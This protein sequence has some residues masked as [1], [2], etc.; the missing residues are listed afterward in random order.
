MLED[1]GG[2]IVEITIFGWTDTGAV[3]TATVSVNLSVRFGSFP[4][5]ITLL[6]LFWTISINHFGPF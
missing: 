5:T 6:K 1:L 4:F 3:D 2:K